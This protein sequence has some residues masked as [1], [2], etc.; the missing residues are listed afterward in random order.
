MC[1]YTLSHLILALTNQDTY[2]TPVLQMMKLEFKELIFPRQQTSD[3]LN[4]N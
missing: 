2:I 4:Q 3:G 1:I